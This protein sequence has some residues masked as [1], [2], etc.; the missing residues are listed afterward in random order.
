[1]K[2]ISIAGRCSI[3]F[4]DELRPV[5]PELLDICAEVVLVRRHGSHFR[6]N[7]PRPDTVEEFDSWAFRAAL[8]QSIEKWSARVVQL[9]FTQMAQYAD[10]CKPA[11]TMLV[12]HDITFDLMQQLL[13]KSEGLQ[14]H[15]LE[16][17]TH[18]ME[19]L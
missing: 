1:V 15:E 17:Q 18:Q 5:A 16:Q 12:E 9:E 10:A 3:A 2:P 4:V 8:R 6:K 14:R 11:K 13:A 7:T 19:E